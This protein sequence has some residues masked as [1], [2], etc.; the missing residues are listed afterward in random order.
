MAQ[1]RVWKHIFQEGAYVFHISG[2]GWSY[3]WL[4]LLKE[5]GPCRPTWGLSLGVFGRIIYDPIIWLSHCSSRKQ[6]RLRV[7]QE[8]QLLNSRLG[9]TDLRRNP[10]CLW[11]TAADS[12]TSVCTP[13][14]FCPRVRVWISEVMLSL[15]TEQIFCVIKSPSLWK[16]T[17]GNVGEE[18]GVSL[19]A[20]KIL[21]IPET[22][23][24]KLHIFH[25]EKNVFLC[26]GIR[27]HQSPFVKLRGFVD[28]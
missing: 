22:L 16:P 26:L 8:P 24:R 11:W 15:S 3:S 9:L 27:F 14:C 17:A 23:L 5:N 4:K 28:F 20:E 13:Q 25:T 18:N 12:S 19:H 6:T 10:T 1:W 2:W 21:G 7:T